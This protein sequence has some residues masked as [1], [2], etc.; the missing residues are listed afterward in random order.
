MFKLHYNE[1]HML[2]FVHQ[3]RKILIG[4]VFLQIVAFLLTTFIL[5]FRSYIAETFL[6]HLMND[7]YIH[8]STKNT[9]DTVQLNVS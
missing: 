8:P 7:Y 1:A 6:E 2:I 3:Y 5:I 4:V 9:M